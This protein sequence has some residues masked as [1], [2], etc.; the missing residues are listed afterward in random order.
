[1]TMRR[2]SHPLPGRSGLLTFDTQTG[3]PTQCVD[4]GPCG[5]DLFEA[6]GGV[7]LLRTVPD[8]REF[9]TDCFTN[10]FVP[11]LEAVDLTTG[12]GCC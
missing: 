8:D 6:A 11:P 5:A 12:M 10:D 1:M 4:T 7:G 2:A 9:A 3:R